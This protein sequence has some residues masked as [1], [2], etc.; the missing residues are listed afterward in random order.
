MSTVNPTT[1]ATRMIQ[2]VYSTVTMW[3]IAIF[4]VVQALLVY[5][6]FRYRQRSGQEREVPEQIHGNTTLEIGWTVLPVIIVAL[7]AFPTLRTLWALQAPPEEGS[8]EVKVTGKRWWFEF[9]YPEYGFVTA[10]ELHLP[11]ERM[12]DLQLQSDNVIHSFWVPKLSGKRDMVPGRG[13]HLWFTPEEPGVYQGQCAE[14]CGAS[15]GLMKFKVFVHTPE[16]FAAWVESQQQ[17]AAFSMANPGTQAFAQNACFTCHAI[18]GTP[19]TFAR[20]GPNLTHVAS[21]STLAGA[22]LENTPEN[23][24]QW[25]RNAGS[26]KPGHAGEPKE[27]DLMWNFEHVPD[28][29]LDALVTWLQ[30]LE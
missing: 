19:W 5:T 18:D 3:V 8:L 4:V 30:T 12:A 11:T 29:Q 7:I 9:E 24:K 16:D 14:L 25:I 21:R 28:E 26:I 17:P 15:H 10:N 2:G 6:V 27:P 22:V 23:M 13:Q 20:I 1:E